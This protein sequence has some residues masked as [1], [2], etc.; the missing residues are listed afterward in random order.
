MKLLCFSLI[1]INAR[2]VKDRGYEVPLTPEDDAYDFEETET[3][4]EAGWSLEKRC[5]QRAVS[6]KEFNLFKPGFYEMKII[7]LSESTFN[8]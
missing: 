8:P 2:E 5:G 1:L 7:C 4:I 6:G 3:E